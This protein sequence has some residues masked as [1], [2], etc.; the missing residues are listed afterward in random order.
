MDQTR[1]LE[2][3]QNQLVEENAYW[4]ALQD[5]NWLVPAPKIVRVFNECGSLVPLWRTP[6]QFLSKLGVDDQTT[7]KFI[8]NIERTRLQDYAAEL[9]TLESKQVKIMRY[10]DKG[11][12]EVLRSIENPPL[13]L[14]HK[15]VLLDF[16]NCV[17]M[18]GT[19]NPTLYGRIMARKIA[20]SLAEKGYVIVSGLARG[21]DEWAHSGAL[22]APKG[23]SIAVLAWMEPIYPEEHVELAKD[24]EKRGA[25]L[26]EIYQS[27]F[28][29]SAPARFV[30]RN[31]ITSG[32][33]RCVIAVESD[34]EGGTVHQ[35]RIA[36]AQKRKVFALEP[37]G[38]DR[39]KR[40]FK[41]FID[42]GATSIKSA[43]EVLRFLSQ[44]TPSSP[45]NSRLDSYYQ[46][47][48]DSERL[49]KDHL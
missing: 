33:S 43:K 22:E 36:L 8:G 47:S 39:A 12:P 24:I 25:V 49:G 32:I 45:D 37:K 6:Y 3:V 23:R 35:V 27:P 29:K 15:G 11:Y 1:P 5:R 42:M 28:N 17:A 26:S 4:L 7:R 30:Q 48:L 46:H 21:V 14:L 34:E 9:K 16:T 19:R 31:R 38:S 20:K 10:V 18:A 2:P 40:G 41:T 13:V 44:E